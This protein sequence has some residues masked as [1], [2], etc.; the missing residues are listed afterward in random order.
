[1]LLLLLL[2]LLWLLSSGQ[3]HCIKI[4]AAYIRRGTTTSMDSARPPPPPTSSPSLSFPRPLPFRV[5]SAAAG[6]GGLQFIGLEQRPGLRHT[7]APR[8]VCPRVFAYAKFALVHLAEQLGA[9]LRLSRTRPRARIHGEV[10]RSLVRSHTVLLH[11][12]EDAEGRI[13]LP[14]SGVFEDERVVADGVGLDPV[15]SHR[16]E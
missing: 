6:P 2:L 8:H 12:S 1:M 13:R 4:T 16:V 3:R 14:V 11:E 5:G 15:R 7:E 9:H 10:V